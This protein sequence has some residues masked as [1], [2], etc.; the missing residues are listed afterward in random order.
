MTPASAVPVSAVAP[1]KPSAT[2]KPRWLPSMEVQLR[3]F[4]D[5]L[6]RIDDLIRNR[7]GMESIAADVAAIYLAIERVRRQLRDRPRDFM[8]A[9]KPRPKRERLP[10]FNPA[11][12]DDD[13]HRNDDPGR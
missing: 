9:A 12:L 2:A 3:E 11:D 5:P 8:P 13:L 6:Q 4:T 1:V 7:V 10:H